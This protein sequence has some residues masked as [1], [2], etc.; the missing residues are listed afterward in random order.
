MIDTH[1][2]GEPAQIR[3]AA[4]W[5]DPEVNAACDAGAT[6]SFRIRNISSGHWFGGSGAAYRE[7]ASELG[8]AGND[9]TT[10]A[11]DAAEKLRSYAGQL[12]RMKSDFAQLCTTALAGGLTVKGTEIHPPVNELGYCP[13]P[14]AD[15]QDLDA[16]E[17]YSDQVAIY[18]EIAGEVGTWWGELELWVADNLDAFHA[19]MPIDDSMS[20]LLDTLG[21]ANTALVGTYLENRVREWKTDVQDLKAESARLSADAARF[22]RQ[23]KSG[24]PGVAAAAREANPRTLRQAARTTDEL[25]EFIRRGGKFLPGI[26]PVLGA[27]DIGIALASG[28]DPSGAIVETVVGALGGVV[29]GAGI[30][31]GAVAL[32]VT[33]PVWVTVVAVG[34]GSV[35]IGAGAVWAYEELVPQDTREMLDAGL[36]DAW[37]AVTDFAE[38]AWTTVSGGASTAQSPALG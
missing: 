34:V 15:Q 23:L 2:P 8:T 5:L 11:M 31:A 30:A 22:Q 12:E 14:G 38:D 27:I 1:V 7:V 18:N 17:A 13:A 20:R 37:D 4:E 19:A 26:G 33:A 16:Y 35:A 6:E 32:G 36:E 9:L 10:Q 21:Y 3:A 28:D 25:A 24:H 29:V